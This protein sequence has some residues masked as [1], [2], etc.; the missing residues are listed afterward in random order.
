MLSITSFS[1]RAHKFDAT[2]NSI[3]NFAFRAY[4][5]RLSSGQDEV[6]WENLPA[7]KLTLVPRKIPVGDRGAAFNIVDS[8]QAPRMREAG[9]L[10]QI[11]YQVFTMDNTA[12]T[13]PIVITAPNEITLAQLVT[14][15][16]LPSDIGAY[17]DVASVFYWNLREIVDVTKADKTK[18]TFE[19]IPEK[20]PIGSNLRV[21]CS[22]L[23]DGSNKKVVNCSFEGVHLPFPMPVDALL[24]RLKARVSDWMK[25]RGQG[26]DW[27][28][29]GPDRE[30]IDF[31]F[32]YPIIPISR[33]MLVKVY[34][35]QWETT[36]APHQSWI[37]VSD[38]LVRRLGLPKSMLFRIYPVVGTVDNQNAVDHSYDITWEPEKQY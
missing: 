17:L 14:Y 6:P 4:I 25:Q 19:A 32:E 21:K 24:E 10:K 20:I 7:P 2:G 27:T 34:L 33:D 28:V 3:G 26:P 13:E 22:S 29:D 16:I 30:A 23:R 9:P 35:K 37:N 8:H 11:S 36:L 1:S 31:D 18:R 5:Y 12:V 15:F 38:A